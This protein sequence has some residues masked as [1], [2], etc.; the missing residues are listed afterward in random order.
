M[1]TSG[2]LHRKNSSMIE[3]LI[4]SVNKT[5]KQITSMEKTIKKAKKV[6]PKILNSPQL[7]QD[8]QSQLIQERQNNYSLQKENEKL[9]KKIHYKKNFLCDLNSLKEDYQSLIESFQR[10]EGIRKKQKEMI[11]NLKMKIVSDERYN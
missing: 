3:D 5:E 8:L 9:R 4:K 7:L 10:S 2:Y 6:H 11:R 1:R